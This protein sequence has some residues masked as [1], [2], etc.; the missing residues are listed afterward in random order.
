MRFDPCKCPE[1]GGPPTATC[2]LVPGNALLQD[3][4]D[5]EFDYAGETKM[6]WDGQYT[7]TDDDGKLHLMCEN[8]HFWSAAVHW[9]N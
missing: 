2:D 8:S 7:E 3:L 1:C 6:C 5:G 4:G 9:P